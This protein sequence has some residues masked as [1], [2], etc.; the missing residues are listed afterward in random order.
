MRLFV[1][2][3]SGLLILSGLV[4]AGEIDQVYLGKFTDV[5]TTAAA[6]NTKLTNSIPVY[7]LLKGFVINFSGTEASPD[8]DIDITTLSTEG[9]KTTTTLYS[10]DDVTADAQKPVRIPSVTTAGVTTGT[11]NSYSEL[12]LV[13]D[14]FV[15]SA[16]DSNTN[17]G[18]NVEAWAVIEK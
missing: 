12:M 15:F 17:A 16:Y 11:T 8:I 1:K 18:I 6:A 3:I 7:G 13:G 4:A 9:S 14:R 2:I 5:K 10:E